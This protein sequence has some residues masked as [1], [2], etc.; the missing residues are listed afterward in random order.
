MNLLVSVP[1]SPGGGIVPGLVRW[2]IRQ[3]HE[4]GVGIDLVEARP[5]EVARNRMV[6]R[7]LATEADWLLMF[8]SDQIPPDDLIPRLLAHGAHVVG[9]FVPVQKDGEVAPLILQR[10]GDDAYR[11]I[12]DPAS[13]VE[14]DATGAGCLLVSRD[15][16]QAVEPP[17]FSVRLTAGGNG[18][19]SEDFVFCG[20]VKDAGYQVYV[21][22]QTRCRHHVKVVM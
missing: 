18:A 9:A 13:L 4:P 21:D 15:V 16:L 19:V 2:L 17:W 20:R 7:F 14:V 1:V 22:T 11:S 8:D 5:V 6:H 10:T 3:S 12:P